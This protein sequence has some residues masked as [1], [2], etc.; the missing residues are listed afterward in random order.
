MKKIIS[1]LIGLILSSQLFAQEVVQLYVHEQESEVARPE[2]ELKHFEKV[3]LQAGKEKTV[4]FQMTSRDF[5][6][7]NSKAHDW[8]VKSG[9][10]DILVG[11][12]SRDLP[13]KQT[14]TIE[15]TN[16]TKIVLTRESLFKEFKKSPNSQAI[17]EQ[18]VQSFTG[19]NK[20]PETEDEKKVASFFEAMLADMPL[21]KLI[22]FSGGKFTEETMNVILKAVNQN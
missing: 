20:K 19:A 14:L 4:S 7:F 3:T 2:N 22:L 9:K 5:A 6:Y 17:Y 15:S 10:F 12:S 1:L 11:S 13:L 18:L 8:T 16:A 21:N